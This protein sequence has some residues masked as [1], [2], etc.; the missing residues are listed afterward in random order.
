VILGST[1]TTPDG[2]G[3]RDQDSVF[4]GNTGK[5]HIN[6]FRRTR[7][8]SITVDGQPN[9]GEPGEG[10][11]VIG[12]DVF[13]L[14]RGDDFFFSFA[15]A[16]PDEVRAGF[17]DDRLLT[18]DGDDVLE[19]A[20]G[21]DTMNG[22]RGDDTFRAQDG[23]RDSI[24]CSTGVDTVDAD[25]QDAPGGKITGCEE[26]RTSPHG[27]PQPAAI[28][29]R[30]KL[31]RRGVDLTLHCDGKRPACRGEVRLRRGRSNVGTQSFSI[32]SGRTVTVSVAVDDST[33]LDGLIAELT[34]RGKRGTRRT[35]TTRASAR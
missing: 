32:R 31:A 4:N 18:G 35:I 11:N 5:D 21:A 23:T 16:Q 6:F 14:G 3:T 12:F 2:F 25:L 20:S 10:A 17:G 33:T 1:A 27:E 24:T 19:G 34:E 8:L 9:D 28:S 7:D 15:D 13:T 29:P 30:A 22:G 26:V